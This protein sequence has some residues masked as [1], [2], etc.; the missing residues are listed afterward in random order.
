MYS[1]SYS[2]AKFGLEA[3]EPLH[4]PRGKSC[5]YYM[6]IVFFFSSLIQ[7]LIIV[8]LVLLFIYGQPE[9]AAGEKRVKELEQNVNMLSEKFN[10]VTKEKAEL[11]TQLG[12]GAAEKAALEKEIT[13][14]KNES[15]T[16]ENKLS[17][18]VTLCQSSLTACMRKASVQQ[19]AVTSS[20]ANS[21]L[22]T[23]KTLSAKQKAMIELISSNFTQ[24]VQTLTRERD[25]AL[26]DRSQFREEVIKLRSDTT[27]Q[28]EQLITYTKKCKED[29]VNSLDGITTVTREFLDRVNNLFPHQLTFHLTCSSQREQMEAIRSSC[30]NLSRD[31][32]SKFQVYLNDVGNQVAE[33]QSK[34]SRLE[35]ENRHIKTSL[36]QCETNHKD[37]VA[38]AASQM[39]S[40][41]K[42][43]D[44]QVAKLLINLNELRKQ[45]TNCTTGSFKGQTTSP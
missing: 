44:D 20:I 8:S 29:F 19:P 24:T 31:V 15:K 12:A 40:K 9:K 41:Q 36:Q 4:K 39:E 13:K 5:G 22:G 45:Q 27:I 23:L 33:I 34:S 32:E 25:N 21:Q 16:R 37:D 26:K 42:A 28:K 18:Q 1:S 38:K 2:R 11:K 17:V 3:R 7:S 35:V 6:R 43:H 14:L 10:S 30:T